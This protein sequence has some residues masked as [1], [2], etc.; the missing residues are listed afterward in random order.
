METVGHDHY[1][2]HEVG[3]RSV[4]AMTPTCLG[5]AVGGRHC[6]HL[7]TLQLSPPPVHNRPPRLL[8]KTDPERHPKLGTHG[9]GVL[10]RPSSRE[11]S[12]ANDLEVLAPCP[13]PAPEARGSG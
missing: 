12:Y 6:R 10:L 7:C 2:P 4:S 5:D 1:D 13:K 9:V 11:L 8:S 3:T